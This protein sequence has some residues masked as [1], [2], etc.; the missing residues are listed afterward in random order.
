MSPRHWCKRKGS[1]GSAKGTRPMRARTPG[2]AQQ[3]L[4]SHRHADAAD[5]SPAARTRPGRGDSRSNERLSIEWR[6]EAINHQ[7]TQSTMTMRI[8]FCLFTIAGG[9]L[10]I[11]PA[12]NARMNARTRIQRTGH[13]MTRILT[14][15]TSL[16]LFAFI[17]FNALSRVR[18]VP[19]GLAPA[20]HSPARWRKSFAR[21]RLLRRLDR[22][23]N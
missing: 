3:P 7:A 5:Q 14:L 23:S 11:T 18:P 15:L 4:P 9:A 10:T 13:S 2:A 17:F 8:H 21:F 20:Q 1:R 16:R 12:A 22:S 19:R 6:S